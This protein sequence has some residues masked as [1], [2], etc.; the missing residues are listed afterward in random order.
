MRLDCPL[1][2]ARDRREFRCRGAALPFP[3]PTSDQ[4][5]AQ[6]RWSARVHLRDNPVG[7]VDELWWHEGGCGSWL[8]VRRDTVS[9]AVLQVS[10]AAGLA[11]LKQ[12]EDEA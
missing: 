2:G 9:H 1:C 12:Q 4:G 3:A 5:E 6:Q 8:V 7:A 10:E 11:G